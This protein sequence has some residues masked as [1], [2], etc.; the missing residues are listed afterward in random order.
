VCRNPYCQSFEAL[1]EACQDLAVVSLLLNMT[2]VSCGVAPDVVIE[3][4]EQGMT[5]DN[6]DVPAATNDHDPALPLP[7]EGTRLGPTG[8]SPGSMQGRAQV[9]GRGTMSQM[10]LRSGCHL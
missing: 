9:R 3:S 5:T 10:T 7:D 8:H 4:I 1:L 2:A 6:F